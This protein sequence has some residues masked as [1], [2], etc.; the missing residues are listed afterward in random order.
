MAHRDERRA[1][2]LC[3]YCDEKF[4]C[5]RPQAFMMIS[6]DETTCEDYEGPPIFDEEPGVAALEEAQTAVA[7]V[8]T[9]RNNSNQT[10][11]VSG[12]H[13]GKELTMLIDGGSSL[14]F[15]SEATISP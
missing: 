4:T 10:I 11:V 15:L 14:S 5:A 7:L 2:G 8:E 9:K 12:L 3:F 13:N 6:S 1:K